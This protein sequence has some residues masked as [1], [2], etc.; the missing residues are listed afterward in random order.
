MMSPFAD[1]TLQSLVI[2]FKL[3]T[4]RQVISPSLEGEHF[5]E[6]STG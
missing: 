1:F 3:E 6:L 4:Q 5:R 2:D